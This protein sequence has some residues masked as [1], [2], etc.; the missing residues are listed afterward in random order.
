[1]TTTPS[2]PTLL[3]TC[4]AWYLPNTARALAA[5][6]SLAALWITDKN[7]MGL[8]GSKYR[9][10][11][12][13]HLAMMPFYLYTPQLWIERAFYALFPIWRAWLKVQKWPRCRVVH[14][15]M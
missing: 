4:G 5:R 9:R 1:M 6:N 15:I 11:W 8:P 7:R 10:C 2:L 13:F 12:P 14:A 3:L